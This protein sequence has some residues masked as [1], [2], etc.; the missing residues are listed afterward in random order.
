MN[1][2]FNKAGNPQELV[3]VKLVWI[4]WLVFFIYLKIFL[5]YLGF[6]GTLSN[7]YLLLLYITQIKLNMLIFTDKFVV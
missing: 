1:Y 3:Q 5:Y 2:L 6:I 7:I 4:L